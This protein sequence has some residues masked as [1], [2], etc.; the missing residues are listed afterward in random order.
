PCNCDAR[1]AVV[2]VSMLLLLPVALLIG[3]S[4]RLHT[5]SIQPDAIHACTRRD[6][7][8]LAVAVTPGDIADPFW[9]ADRT[10]VFSVRG[11]N[12]NPTRT[13]TVEVAFLVNADA[14]WS[15]SSLGGRC[16]EKEAP[17]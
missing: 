16:V 10:Q 4:S 3:R 5:R 8:C 2:R 11:D 9:N 12:P 17:S 15:A 13:R 7:Q 6:V 14:I 1:A